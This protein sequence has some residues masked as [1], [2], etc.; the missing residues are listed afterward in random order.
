MNDKNYIPFGE[1]WQK[2]LSKF[3]KPEI[4]RMLSEAKTSMKDRE[5]KHDEELANNN[6]Y[7]AMD[8]ENRHD[9][10][11]NYLIERITHQRDIAVA[12]MGDEANQAVIAYNYAIHMINGLTLDDF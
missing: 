4:I 8:M 7:A 3:P 5:S 1:E 11:M 12:M 9:K 10:A 2:E 6:S